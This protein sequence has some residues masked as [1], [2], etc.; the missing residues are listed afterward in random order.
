MTLVTT[1]TNTPCVQK[2]ANSGVPYFGYHW[3][4]MVFILIEVIWCFSISLVGRRE[5]NRIQ[6]MRAW[7]KLVQKPWSSK[8]RNRSKDSWINHLT[9]ALKCIENYVKTFVEYIIDFIQT[10]FSHCK[11]EL[12]FSCCF[13]THR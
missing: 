9:I 6:F 11:N 7:G 12:F 13:F 4:T 8:M 10:H 5:S 3:W 2:L 1:N